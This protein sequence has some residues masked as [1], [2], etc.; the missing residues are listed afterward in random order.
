MMGSIGGKSSSRGT[1]A[2]P[3]S[4]ATHVTSSTT[5]NTASR[6][7]GDTAHAGGSA[8]PTFKDNIGKLVAAITVGV[9]SI[10]QLVL[11]YSFKTFSFVLGQ[12]QSVAASAMGCGKRRSRIAE[13]SASKHAGASGGRRRKVCMVLC[14]LI[15]CCVAYQYQYGGVGG[16]GGGAMAMTR[17][18][19][20]FG[21]GGES[22]A[23]AS[24]VGDGN[25]GAHTEH[26][27]EEDEEEEV[28][29][30]HIKTNVRHSAEDANPN[31]GSNPDSN[32]DASMFLLSSSLNELVASSTQ[33]NNDGV[34]GGGRADVG[35]KNIQRYKVRIQDLESQV[36]KLR[37]KLDSARKCCANCN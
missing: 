19:L 28:V 1:P 21:S 6:A 17:R 26:D 8:S 11:L 20:R 29:E 36:E 13:L 4:H 33:H 32:P 25:T 9:M 23:S 7:G 5:T 30:H 18:F 27:E 14:L 16:E 2:R 34:G 24:N 3:S 35:A 31:P 22:S 12:V 37:A 10:V 15:T